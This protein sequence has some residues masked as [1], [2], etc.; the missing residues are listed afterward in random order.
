MDQLF[1]KYE[2]FLINKLFNVKDILSN[3]HPNKF[4]DTKLER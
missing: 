4:S 2:G 1:S 3:F